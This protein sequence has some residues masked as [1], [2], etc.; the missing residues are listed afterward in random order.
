MRESTIEIEKI[1]QPASGGDP[2]G[3]FKIKQ[4]IDNKLDLIGWALSK[5]IPLEGV[6]VVA[7]GVVV[8]S[9]AIDIERPDVGREYPEVTGSDICGFEISIE[10]SGQGR[11][12]LDIQTIGDDGTRISIGQ[13]SV[14]VSS[15]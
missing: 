13:I 1:V 5:S 7:N 10:G 8:A 12:V 15:S 14:I 6:E 9:A 4:V 11:S 2:L 3:H